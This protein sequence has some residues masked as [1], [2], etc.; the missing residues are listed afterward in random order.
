MNST[1]KIG[2]NCSNEISISR[3]FNTMLE[4]FKGNVHL[5][6]YNIENVP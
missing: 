4:I 2:Y 1:K 3:I 5:K 6:L